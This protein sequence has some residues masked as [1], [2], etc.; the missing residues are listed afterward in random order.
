MS[1]I[2]KPSFKKNSS[3]FKPKTFDPVRERDQRLHKS[4]EWKHFSRKYLEINKECYVC[5]EKSQVTDH[6]RASK[7]SEE[8]FWKEGNFLPLCTVCHNT[9]TGRFDYKTSGSEEDVTRKVKW[10]NIE[11][12]RNQIL[13]D[14]Q[15]SRP[16]VV[17]ILTKC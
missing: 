9:V 4:E 13:K 2:F 1:K 3:G 7:G 8:W 12:D 11:R 15:F 17:K 14:R 6:I 5:G 10:M 16:K